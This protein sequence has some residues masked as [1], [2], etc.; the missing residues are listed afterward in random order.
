MGTN[1]SQSRKIEI[2]RLGNEGAY[3]ENGLRRGPY[4]KTASSPWGGEAGTWLDITSVHELCLK[5]ILEHQ[6]RPSKRGFGITTVNSDQ[7]G[8]IT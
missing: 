6:I 3:G 2:Q 4:C 5:K 7:A 8:A 1:Y